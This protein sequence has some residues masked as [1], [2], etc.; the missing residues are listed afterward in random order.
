MKSIQDMDACQ[1]IAKNVTT[2]SKVYQNVSI[3][4]TRDANTGTAM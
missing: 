4:M 1:E 2:S 3:A